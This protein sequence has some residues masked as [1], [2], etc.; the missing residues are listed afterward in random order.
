MSKRTIWLD[1][2]EVIVNFLGEL[3][4]QYNIKYD[5]NVKISDIESWELEP[6]IGK[7]GINIFQQPGFFASLKPIPGAIETIN[8]LYNEGHKIFII[9]KPENK[10]S[11]VEKYEWVEKYLPFLIDNLILVRNKSEFL[12]MLGNDGILFDDCAEYLEIYKGITVAMNRPYNYICESYY[13][14]DNW[15]GFYEIV[16]NLEVGDTYDKT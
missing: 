2:D 9:S 1:M 8:K 6:Y 4:Y 12:N 13:K 11:V 16:K 5:K 10:Y 14:V 7:E 3:F 15:D